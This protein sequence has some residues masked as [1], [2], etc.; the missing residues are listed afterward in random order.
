MLS[1]RPGLEYHHIFLSFVNESLL[2]G[3]S[4]P[5]QYIEQL[6]TIRG[7]NNGQYIPLVFALHACSKLLQ[8]VIDP[9]NSRNFTFKPGVIRI[10]TWKLDESDST[11]DV[12]IKY[13]DHYTFRYREVIDLFQ[14][15]QPPR[16]RWSFSDF[17]GLNLTCDQ[18][19]QE[20]FYK[21]ALK[22]R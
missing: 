13:F 1:K 11:A 14:R 16:F 6:Y 10:Y 18:G 3:H 17:Y 15:C 22:L 21:T 20:K 12:D 2:T 5:S 8:H 9:S 19:L 4:N 7:Y